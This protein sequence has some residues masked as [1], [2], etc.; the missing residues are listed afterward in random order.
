M[1]AKSGSGTGNSASR[2]ARFGKAGSGR[3]G[4]RLLTAAAL[5]TAAVSQPGCG[6]K[7]TLSVRVVTAPGTADPFLN[8]STVRLV[9]GTNQVS[10]AVSGGKFQVDLELDSPPTDQFLQI[11]VEAID[12][13][14]TVV[15]RGITPNFDPQNSDVAVYVNRSGQVGATDLQLP[16]DM[17]TVGSARGRR[18]LMGAALIGRQV[19]PA[20]PAIG[21]LIVGGAGDDGSLV[22]QAAMYKTLTHQLIDAGS[23]SSAGLASGA[24]RGGVLVATADATV[25][26]Q[27]VLWGGTQAGGTLPTH[28]DKFDPAVSTLAMVWA[29]P[30]MQY[31][32]AGVGAYQP[33]V[34]QVGALHLIC[35]GID[36]A[37]NPLDHAVLVRRNA[38]AATSVDQSALIGVTR[39]PPVMDK[40]PMTAR[41][42]QHTV[43]G[44]ADGG[45]GFV[46]G[47]LSPADNKDPAKSA[48]EVF[49]IASNS[50]KE[51]SF[52]PPASAPPSRR[53]H[54]AT[55]LGSGQ[56][57]IVGGYSFDKTTDAAVLESGGL[58]I[59]P[60]LRTVTPLPQ[61]LKT[62]R[63][64]ASLT[65]SGGEIVICGGF[66]GFAADEKALKDCEALS[67]DSGMPT[68]GGITLPHARAGHLALTLENGLTLLVG[69]AAAQ[70]GPNLSSID[71]YSALR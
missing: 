56:I 66:A 71:I 3:G 31:R 58:I 11:L 24:R 5:L 49:A 60:V 39:V 53:G 35:G 28:A 1:T 59:D 19:S 65:V 20:E 62:P 10:A 30:D 52:E 57:L 67:V 41:R 34:G 14:G 44:T 37:A 8:A 29:L 51:F 18:D 26:Q 38:P 70:N 69:G 33:S 7:T 13:S 45:T 12:S 47:G 40:G 46:F 68:R 32:D 2:G 50:F 63:Y 48:A 6:K 55:R 22:N 61:L 36:T 9:Q 54:L 23:P 21:A 43:T 17:F 42:Y 15:A 25:G 4:R 64:A 16:D 27:A